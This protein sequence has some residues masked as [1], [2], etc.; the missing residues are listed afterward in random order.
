M[1]R[2]S[3]AVGGAGDEDVGVEIRLGTASDAAALAAIYSAGIEGRESTF[4]TRP[5]TADEMLARLSDPAEIHLVALVDGDVVGWAATAPYS[6]REVYAGVAE[7][8]VYV[9]R[10]ARGRGVGTALATALA[11]EA[12]ARG[13]HKLL[14]KL[15]VENEASR[16]L[17]ARCGFREV[18]THLR[19][20]R[21]DGEWRD[22]LL[23][24][25]LLGRE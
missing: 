23:V 19:H 1:D 25:L 11:D 13:L 16:R 10:A 24:E 18:G 22:V 9:L 2:W 12:S 6:T 14:G 5:R 17:V 4:E 21:L 3:V 7:A 15:F 8:S 20:G